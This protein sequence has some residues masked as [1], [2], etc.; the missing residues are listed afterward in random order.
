MFKGI[1]KLRTY[2]VAVTVQIY[3]NNICVV[4]TKNKKV[5]DFIHYKFIVIWMTGVYLKVLIVKK[6]LKYSPTESRK[7]EV[8]GVEITIFSCLFRIYPIFLQRIT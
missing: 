7:S 5:D 8:W 4:W 3:S 6:W 2:L 1:V